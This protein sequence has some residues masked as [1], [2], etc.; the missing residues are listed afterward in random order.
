MTQS[1]QQ[2]LRVIMS[3]FS[4]TTR[5]ALACNDS[6]KIIEPIQSR[7]TILRYGKIKNEEMEDR[8]NVVISLENIIAEEEGIKALIE[9]AEGDMRYALNNMQST[10][11][12]FGKVTKDNVYKIVDVP[13]PEIIN[14]ILELTFERNLKNA[15]DKVDELYEEGYNT[16][17]IL[18]T[19][20]KVIQNKNDLNEDLKMDILMEISKTK[21]RVLEGVN[22]SLQIYGLLAAILKLLN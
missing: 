3:D 18:G 19:I 15:I 4:N 11:V 5:F 21:M 12:G 22:S 7:C 20:S 9:T 13:K 2:A 14:K 10:I 1:A 8:L 6:T 16:L 17:D